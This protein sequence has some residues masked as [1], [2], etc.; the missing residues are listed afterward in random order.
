MREFK[1]GIL[2]H[3]DYM[4]KDAEGRRVVGMVLFPE[5]RKRAEEV[6]KQLKAA[7]EKEIKIRATIKYQHTNQYIEGCV[8]YFDEEAPI[9]TMQDLDE[10][11][12]HL[13][14]KDIVSIEHC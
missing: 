11:M 12:H 13:F 4:W 5:K 10:N 6:V 1:Q 2:P 8:V 14:I 7:Y 3:W 9:F